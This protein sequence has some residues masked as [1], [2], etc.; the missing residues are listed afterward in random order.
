[1]KLTKKQLKDLVEEVISDYDGLS[2][3]EEQILEEGFSDVVQK[4]RS[5]SR[6][7]IRGLL[8]KAA[9]SKTN[10]KIEAALDNVERAAPEQKE[11]AINSAFDTAGYV[12]EQLVDVFDEFEVKF[13]AINN[14]LQT[15]LKQSAISPQTLQRMGEI[16][17]FEDEDVEKTGPPKGMEDETGT[18]ITGPPKGMEDAEGNRV[19]EADETHDVSDATF[20]LSAELVNWAVTMEGFSDQLSAIAGTAGTGGALRDALE[21]YAEYGGMSPSMGLG[22]A[23][24]KKKKSDVAMSVVDNPEQATGLQKTRKPRGGVEKARGTRAPS[25]G[26]GK[27]SPGTIGTRTGGRMEETID[28]SENKL[29]KLINE[30][31]NNK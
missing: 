2:L 6:S 24:P 5:S 13:R 16:L 7:A 31:T 14:K 3:L 23:N 10:R 19:T 8:R 29:K 1:M 28:F 12:M 22:G 18:V 21:K 9:N 17:S 4:M 11:E 27:M 20:R 25:R 30:Y 15:R 26:I